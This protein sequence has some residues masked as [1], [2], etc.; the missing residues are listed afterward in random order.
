MSLHDELERKWPQTHI[1]L[2]VE[3]LSKMVS[4][5]TKQPEHTCMFWLLNPENQAFEFLG[6]KFSKTDCG[7]WAGI[8]HV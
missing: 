4:R 6:W 5:E 3:T 1:H 8:C 7:T 2:N